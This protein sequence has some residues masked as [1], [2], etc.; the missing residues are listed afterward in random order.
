MTCWCEG[1]L[2]LCERRLVQAA[3]SS[4]TNFLAQLYF[5][6]EASK[7]NSTEQLG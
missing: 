2:D 1:L 7:L 3:L 5:C 4:L 6:T